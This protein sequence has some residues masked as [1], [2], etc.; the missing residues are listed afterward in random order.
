MDK[1]IAAPGVGVDA[2]ILFLK[3]LFNYYGYRKVY[4]EVY[5]F[6]TDVVKMAGKAGFVLE[7]CLKGHRW[8]NGRFWDQ[9]IYAITGRGFS[10]NVQRF[11]SYLFRHRV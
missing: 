10:S 1:N 7:G 5:A 11:A 9:H 4:V 6:N 8:W 2:S 3:Y